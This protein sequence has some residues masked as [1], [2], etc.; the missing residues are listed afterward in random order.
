MVYKL[1]TQLIKLRLADSRRKIKYLEG[2]VTELHN[3]YT[4]EDRELP[5]AD[6]MRVLSL[7]TENLRL[8]Y[9]IEKD[10]VIEALDK[11]IVSLEGKWVKLRK[12]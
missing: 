2:L 12:K 7:I 3:L 9:M 6:K 4:D 5:Y 10:G 8:L 11:K 1:K